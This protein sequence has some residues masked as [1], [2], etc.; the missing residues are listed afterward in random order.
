VTTTVPA[1]GMTA[2]RIQ[3]ADLTARI[4]TNQ[5]AV[6]QWARRYFGSWW[7]AE[8]AK[9]DVEATVQVLAYVDA[10]RYHEIAATVNALPHDTT[11]Y[12]GSRTFV[13]SGW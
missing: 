3:V 4:L 10:V 7:Q 13:D 5:P 2:V 1:A 9:P 12:Y 8:P 11:T 6:T